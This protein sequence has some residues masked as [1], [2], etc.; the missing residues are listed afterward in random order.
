LALTPP[1]PRP[2]QGQYVQLSAMTGPAVLKDI[3]HSL[4]TDERVIRWLLVKKQAQPRLPKL[5]ELR[6]IESELCVPGGRAEEGAAP[7]PGWRLAAARA[8]RHAL[9]PPA[10]PSLH[11]LSP[12]I[13]ACRP[14]SPLSLLPP[15]QARRKDAPF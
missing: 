7:S 13:G 5:K 12:N 6:R 8:S 3:T 15:V 11:L 2:A 1:I 10:V 4:R 14:P 9:Q